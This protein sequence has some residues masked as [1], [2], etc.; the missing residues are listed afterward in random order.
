M[1]EA[2]PYQRPAEDVVAALHSDA[3][4][5]LSQDEAGRRLERYGQNELAAERP[6][7][8]RKKFLA[9]LRRFCTA[10]ANSVLWLR[11]LSKLLRR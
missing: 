9:Q 11:E 10:V 6:T 5:G 8:A 7:P 2:E 4:A 3:Q 1:A